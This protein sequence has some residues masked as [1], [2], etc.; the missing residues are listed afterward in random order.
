MDEHVSMKELMK[1]QSKQQTALDTL[2]D[3]KCKYLLYGG[4]MAGGKSYLLRWAALYYCLWIAQTYGIKGVPVGLFSEDYPTLKDRQISRIVREFPP[5]LGELKESKEEGFAF[6]LKE[7]YGGGRILLR[8]LD[9]PSKYMSSEFAGIFVDELTRNSEQTFQD[10][11]NRLRYPG[12]DQV[13]FMGA[14]N[15]GGVG[16]GWVRKFFIDKSAYG[17]PEKER[18]FYVHA[19]AYDNKFISVDYIHQLESLP[20]KKR[21]AY[22]EGNW[23]IFEGQVFMEFDREKHVINPIVPRDAYSLVGGLD[24][25]Y[26][27]PA[28][29]LLGALYPI[30]VDGKKFSRLIIY[31]EVDGI[32]MT[33]EA[34]AKKWKE[35]IPEFL[36]VKIWGDPAMFNKLQDSSFSIAD[37]FRREGVYVRKSTN[38]RLNGIT[39]IHNWLGQAPDGLPFLQITDTCRSLIKTLPEAM[40]DDTVEEDVEH[41]WSE[42]HWYDS[43]RYLTAM[44][45]WVDTKVGGVMRPAG[46]MGPGTPKYQFFDKNGKLINIDPNRFAEPNIKGGIYYK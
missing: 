28:V 38:N 39:T 33:P 27:A 7:H 17:D 29:L 12:I 35:T 13:K 41:N 19:N 30:E 22:L 14:S 3:P 26:S 6:F 11:R 44:L 20:L 4:A 10:L 45:K 21:K 18:F 40:Y 36:R 23:D 8:N 2:F 1:L 37:Q 42:D 24:W 9:D 25:G 31:K 32:E 15:P 46:Q 43:L 16:H 5:Y 34:W